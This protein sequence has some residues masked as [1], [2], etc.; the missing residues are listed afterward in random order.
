VRIHHYAL[1]LF[2]CLV[3]NTAQAQDTYVK[4]Q[5]QDTICDNRGVD[6]FG[7]S[8]IELCQGFTT[9]NPNAEWSNFRMVGSSCWV[10]QDFLGA[11]TQKSIGFAQVRD[12]LSDTAADGSGAES[13]CALYDLPSE[14]DCA[15]VRE[16]WDNGEISFIPNGSPPGVD[17]ASYC[18]PFY[19]DDDNECSDVLGYFNDH[20]L[21]NDDKNACESAG[22]TYGVVAY[23]AQP[24][25]AV[26]I[27]D[28]F[29][30][31]LPTC[32]VATVHYINGPET[33]DPGLS[34]FACAST[35]LGG[36]ED[37]N[38]QDPSS[39]QN[40]QDK[41]DI[42][43]DGVPD[44]ID[45]DIDGDGIL[46]GSDPD[47]DGDGVL[48]VDDPTPQG[49]QQSSASGGGTCASRPSCTGDAVQCAIL[50]QTWLSRCESSDGADGEG[51]DSGDGIDWDAATGFTLTPSDGP[52]TDPADQV[53]PD[54]GDTDLSGFL[55]GLTST[56]GPSGSCPSPYALPLTSGSQSFEW[57]GVCSFATT[58]R[59]LVLLLF[60]LVAVRITLRAFD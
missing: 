42:D 35:S 49:E 23:G 24:E 20:Q 10:T 18:S 53:I 34:A 58:I 41:A 17:L 54:E 38:P 52:L 56:S 19:S 30:D 15:A 48:D 12:C 9:S 59:P 31:Q 1:I 26:C 13:A 43:G 25:T 39:A 46:N 3:A 4:A 6:V 21:C 16:G 14:V 50:V 60:A 44:R 32:D 5:C 29:A 40:T 37:P 27:P 55:S 22:G 7:F 28:D 33:S 2:A 57:T 8:Q 51:G 36:I 45:D 47:Q 11:I